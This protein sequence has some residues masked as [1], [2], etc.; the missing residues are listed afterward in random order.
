VVAARFASL[1]HAADATDVGLALRP[2]IIV[3][4]WRQRGGHKADAGAPGDC[5]ESS[6]RSD[7]YW[8]TMWPNGSLFC[9]FTLSTKHLKATDYQ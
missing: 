4:I 5:F 8:S 1:I 3:V 7:H 9:Q 6:R 2:T